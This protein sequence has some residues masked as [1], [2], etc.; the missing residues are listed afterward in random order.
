MLFPS[1]SYFYIVYNTL[2]P[3]VSHL[4]IVII[5]SQ[6][7][8]VSQ[9]GIYMF[10]CI[11][12]YNCILFLIVSHCYSFYIVSEVTQ[13]SSIWS[14]CCSHTHS[15]TIWWQ[16]V[17]YFVKFWWNT[18]WSFFYINM[19]FLVSL[20]IIILGKHIWLRPCRLHIVVV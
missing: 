20:C 16:N 1:H 19:L 18:L 9:W 15:L 3:Y 10:V 14:K 5:V 12:Y 6:Q 13:T 17:F 2:D 8:V 4:I 7:F 11:M